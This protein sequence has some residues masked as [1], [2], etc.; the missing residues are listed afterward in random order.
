MLY[1]GT[2]SV[3]PEDT[4]DDLLV[5]SYLA[6]RNRQTGEP[7]VKSQAKPGKQLKVGGLDGCALDPMEA[8]LGDDMAMKVGMQQE[9]RER[10]CRFHSLLVA[11]CALRAQ[12]REAS[13]LKFL[14]PDSPL[15]N[16][17]QNIGLEVIHLQAYNGVVSTVKEGHL[18]IS[19][20]DFMI[21]ATAMGREDK[22]DD[23]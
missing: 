14:G 6:S 17:D 20:P 1:N 21:L 11:V 13:P 4:E 10:V 16:Q 2:H 5:K 23:G 19:E 18:L 7:L 22:E 8:A 12:V 3:F 15:P 9:E